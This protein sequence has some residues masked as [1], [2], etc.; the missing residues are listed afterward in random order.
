MTLD[1]LERPKR[2]LAE[3]IVL[4]S[5]QEKYEKSMIKNWGHCC[6]SVLMQRKADHQSSRCLKLSCPCFVIMN[7]TYQEFEAISPK[8]SVLADF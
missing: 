4:Q 8:F 5:P 6:L 1:D 2:T 7:S 3:K